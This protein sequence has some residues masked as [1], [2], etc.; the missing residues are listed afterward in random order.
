MQEKVQT[1]F[2]EIGEEKTRLENFQKFYA[3]QVLYTYGG[4]YA[5]AAKILGIKTPEL[6]SMVK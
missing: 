6:K 4:E 1:A 3:R 2:Q 5:P